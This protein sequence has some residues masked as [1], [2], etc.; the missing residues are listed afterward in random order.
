MSW[1]KLLLAAGTLLLLGFA[2][3]AYDYFDTG[4]PA[5]AAMQHQLKMFGAAIYEYH[6]ATGSWPTRIDDLARTSLPQRSY[7]WQQIARPIVF[8]WPQQLKDDPKRQ[9]RRAVGV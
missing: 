9:R 3:L 7:N 5:H 1:N 2:R 4:S 8:L 6:G